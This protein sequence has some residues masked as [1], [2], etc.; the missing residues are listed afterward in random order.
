MNE[1]IVK[2]LRDCRAFLKSS[3]GKME[4]LIYRNK[5]LDA[6]LVDS[7]LEEKWKKANTNCVVDEQLL[8]FEVD[9]SIIIPL[10][11][12][13]RFIDKCLNSFLHQKTKFK[14]EL[15]LVD[16]GSTDNTNNLAKAYSKLHPEIIK[17]ITQVN[18]GISA[19]R[20]TGIRNSRGKYIGFADHDDWVS[21][22]YIEV[23][24][25]K[26]FEE[27]ADIVK[28]EFSSVKNGVV[29]YTEKR[30]PRVITGMMKDSL[31]EYPS[32]IWGGVYR[33]ELLERVQKKE[34]FWYEDMITRMLLYR[35]SKVFVDVGENLYFKLIHSNNASTKVWNDK[36]YKCLEQ[37]YLPEILYAN[38]RKLG[39]SE[40]VY[41]YECLLLEYSSI[42][43]QRTKRLPEEI[44]Q[45]VFLYARNVLMQ[46]YKSEF[47][48]LMNSKWKKWN[49]IILEK[50]YNAW[51]ALASI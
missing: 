28:C 21:E 35:Q 29:N 15:I 6:K 25:E 40:D 37:L 31:F 51:K 23:L 2:I 36:D 50:K 5:V 18:G 44:Q 32:Y 17:V 33:R 26:A 12:S 11:N 24:L 1:N 43:F 7:K 8:P 46:L 19:A 49:E 22:N 42:L 16:D 14:Y 34:K 20:N 3:K 48:E 4:Y 38:A 30:I 10:Y 27:T 9:L 47:D 41:A 13:E 45:Q 39:L